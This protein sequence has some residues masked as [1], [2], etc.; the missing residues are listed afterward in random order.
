M[1]HDFIVL[2]HD[3]NCT[4]WRVPELSGDVRTISQSTFHGQPE[5][6]KPIQILEY[7]G[8][9]SSLPD[10]F[11]CNGLNDWYTGSPQPLWFDI[12]NH[13]RFEGGDSI[14]EFS[15]YEVTYDGISPH[16]LSMKSISTFKIDSP[17]GRTLTPY[18]V[19]EENMVVPW[20]SSRGIHCHTGYTKQ[21]GQMQLSR[22]NNLCVTEELMNQ[23]VVSVCPVAG[24]LVYFSPLDLNI[25]IIDLFRR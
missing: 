25:K 9:F 18:R 17:Q 22:V 19:C 13:A 2:L 24:R 7:G 16:C 11:C 20:I 4:V 21:T 1:N 8:G 6:Q 14:L 5:G 15:R 10:Q 3:D 12:V 23:Y